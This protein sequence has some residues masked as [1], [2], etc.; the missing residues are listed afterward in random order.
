[1]TAVF[2]PMVLSNHMLLADRPECSRVASA[3]NNAYTLTG[4]VPSDNFG[5][6]SLRITA[7]LNCLAMTSWIDANFATDMKC[8]MF[9]Y[10]I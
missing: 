2:P 4:L 5:E 10:E 7:P 3:G 6:F 9:K 8:T 1:V